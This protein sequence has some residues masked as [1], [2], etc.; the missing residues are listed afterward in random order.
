MMSD[1]ANSPASARTRIEIPEP[2]LVS[3][4]IPPWILRHFLQF[5]DPTAEIL[6]VLRDHCSE[7]PAEHEETFFSTYHRP[8]PVA[9]ETGQEEA[10]SSCTPWEQIRRIVATAEKSI[11]GRGSMR[12]AAEIA[13]EHFG[14][15]WLDASD[16]TPDHDI[17]RELHEL[18]W[19]ALPSSHSNKSVPWK[20][21][22]MHVQALHKQARDQAQNQDRRAL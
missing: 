15:D 4:P 19:A 1:P 6:K 13:Y 18:M 17:R 16:G 9:T 8:P 7:Q 21:F 14:A 3:V 5:E 10:W 12:R 2:V 20:R 22:Q 11:E